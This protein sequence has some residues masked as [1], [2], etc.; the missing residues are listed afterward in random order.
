MRTRRQSERYL[1]GVAARL[2]QPQSAAISAVTVVNISPRGCCAEGVGALEPR[3]RYLLS[4]DWRAAQIRAEAEV[5][6]SDAQ[7]RIGL[8]FVSVEKQSRELLRELC[9]T[10][11]IQPSSP[12]PAEAENP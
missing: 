7:G 11:R 9:S 6:W 8:K 3:Q 5:A 10:L 1:F 2:S 4:I 12:P